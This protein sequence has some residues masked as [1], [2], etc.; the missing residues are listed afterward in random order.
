VIRGSLTVLGFLFP[1]AFFLILFFNDDDGCS[2]D[3]NKFK[4]PH[5]S[6]LPHLL[7]L[8]GIG[9]QNIVVPMA[10]FDPPALEN[11]GYTIFFYRW[12]T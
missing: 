11:L 10:I 5:L 3:L 9:N 8:Y 1:F 2:L 4:D 7:F 6:R 12:H